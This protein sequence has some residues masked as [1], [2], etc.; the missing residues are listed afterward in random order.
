MILQLE[1]IIDV[2][3]CLYPDYEYLFLFD[4]SNGHDRLQPDGLS[5]TK[6]SKSFGGKQPKMR[7]SKLTESC[8]GPFHTPTYLLQ[9][10]MY[11]QMWFPK[12]HR[13]PFY[14]SDAEKESRRFDKASGKQVKFN[15]TRDELIA[16]LAADGMNVSK[17]TTK[18]KCIQYCNERGIAT[19]YMRDG[20]IEGWEGNPKGSF[21][22]LYERG[23]IDPSN[24]SK[25]TQNGTK[26]TMG[27][28][29][30][31]TS[32]KLLMEK[33]PDFLSELTLLQYHA[34]LLGAIVD[35]S[36]KCHPELAGE[37]I[38]YA[39]ALAKLFY[40]SQRYELKR[41]K[42][43]FISLVRRS[44][45]R[46]DILSIGQVRKC[47]RRARE[48]MLAYRAIENVE[49]QMKFQGAQS[50]VSISYSMIEKIIKTYKT[51]RNCLDTDSKWLRQ[52]TASMGTEQF[53]IMK[54]V[55][56]KM[57]ELKKES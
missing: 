7:P 11:Q 18:K 5:I 20:I 16:R 29:L 6:I 31:A 27:I 17:G 46:N 2:L 50:D 45:S 26:D 54:D 57:D 21:Q 9:P 42:D 22:I 25:Y 14:L 30:E 4:H 8:F 10:G 28:L 37:G 53:N 15:Y 3:K 36:P 33:Q 39:W 12:S 32:L 51:H 34:T 56:K 19:T 52:T 55:V 23:W 24:F 13:G 47:S 1:D 41:K 38:E 44:T 40:R 43:N 49:S 48:Y 35:R